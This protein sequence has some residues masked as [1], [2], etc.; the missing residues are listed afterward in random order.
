MAINGFFSRMMG[1][2]FGV[3]PHPATGPRSVPAG[4]L[5]DRPG[6]L[7][8]L[9][10]NAHRCGGRHHQPANVGSSS[11]SPG[12]CGVPAPRLLAQLLDGGCLTADLGDLRDLRERRRRR[13]AHGRG[14]GRG[15]PSA[16][17]PRRYVLACGSVGRDRRG[18][19]ARDREPRTPS[20]W[21]VPA[22]C[23]SRRR[24]GSRCPKR[25]SNARRDRLASGS[26]GHS[27]RHVQ[28]RGQGD[29]V[30]SR[31]RLLVRQHGRAAR[32]IDGG[33]RRA[34]RPAHPA[35]HR[36]PGNRG[37]LP[38]VVVRRSSTAERWCSGSS[39]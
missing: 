16:L 38:A 13:V 39:P 24:C 34:G 15:R 19:G 8:P 4:A 32:G 14:R 5:G 30:P 11:D 17:P 2:I 1:V 3:L 20:W 35:G 12:R 31:A 29:A 7:V 27:Y 9:V 23:C 22:N 26:I 10:R 33:V 25:G 18:C 37:A 6:G 36:A 28:R 21:Q